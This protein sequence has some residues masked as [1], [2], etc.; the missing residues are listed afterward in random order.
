[1]N[2]FLFLLYIVILVYVYGRGYIAGYFKIHDNINNWI[3][4][5]YE[6]N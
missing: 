3:T 6:D 1:M 4:E 2:N 5:N